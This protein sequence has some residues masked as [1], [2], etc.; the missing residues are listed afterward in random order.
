V[1]AED[2]EGDT[3]EMARIVDHLDLSQEQKELVER[4]TWIEFVN[5]VTGQEFLDVLAGFLDQWPADLVWINPYTAYLGN[6]IKD[7]KA[8]S[9]FLRNSLNP[10][11]TD[12]G[13]AA[14]I[15]HHTP[16]TNFRDTTDW[17]QSDWMYAGA[18]AAVLTNWARGVIVIDP[19]VTTGVY[20]FIA[21]KRGKR[22][23]WKER[24]FSHSRDSEKLLWIP[25]SID[26]IASAR[27]SPKQPEELL[28]LIPVGEPIS[29]AELRVLARQKL[30][31]GQKKCDEFTAILAGKMLI[32]R[33][34]I[35]RVGA[36][37][38]IG[39]SRPNSNLETRPSL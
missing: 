15:I 31:M 28:K 6:D 21:A 17:K 37:S 34:K 14:N 24:Y 36:K 30:G 25:S 22:I 20:R 16:K 9:L 13:C 3:I 1:Q 33:H 27:N 19:T 29:Q 18:G 39:Y 23:G 2:D 11:L 12:H 8:N 38:A 10:I 5:N 35:P 4:N 26:E 7:D 32:I